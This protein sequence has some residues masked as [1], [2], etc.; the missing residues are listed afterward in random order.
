MIDPRDLRVYLVTDP[1]L[2]GDRNLV[3]VVVAAVEGGVTC[4]QLRDKRATADQLSDV[5]R[6]LRSA[7][8]SYDVPVLVNDRVDVAA[9]V[10]AT[11][12]H[13]GTTDER[14][15]TARDRLGSGAVIGWSVER[16]DQLGSPQLAACS[17]LAVSPVW[18]TP[19]KT[20]TTA[21]LGLAGVSAVRAGTHLPLVGIGGVD[22]ERAGDVIRAGADG[23]AVVSA[24]CA[25]DDPEAAARKIRS[26]VDAA[27]AERSDQR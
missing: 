15:A 17:Y 6:R 19:T 1:V 9:A 21:P 18:A 5:W 8:A 14:P 12:V 11:G 16:L 7:L 13:L 24:I 22:A 3:D 2:I 20:D 23:V 4:V 26:A 27:L 10:E 25:A